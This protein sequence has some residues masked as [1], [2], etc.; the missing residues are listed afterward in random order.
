MRNDVSPYPEV[1]FKREVQVLLWPVSEIFEEVVKGTATGGT[2]IS[3]YC[4]AVSQSDREATIRLS[5]SLP[6]D[7]ATQPRP[8]LIVSINVDGQRFANMAIDGITDYREERGARSMTLTCRSRDSFGL[9]RDNRFVTQVY[10]YGTELSA[11]A[12]DIARAMGLGAFERALPVTGH[13]TPHTNCQ[14]SD[15][16]PWEM[17]TTLYIAAGSSPVFDARG[18]LKTYSRDITRPVDLTIAME[19]VIAITGSKARPPIT[20]VKVKWLSRHLSKVSQQD[21][22]ITRDTVT[23]GFFKLE[24]RREEWFSEDRTQRA[25]KTYMKV[26]QSVNSGLLPVGDEEYMQL[27]TRHGELVVTTSAWVPALATASIIAMFAAT[28]I[29]DTVAIFE[30]IPVGRIIHGA[31]EVAILLTMMSLGTG[32]YEFWGQPFDYVHAINTT[33]AFAK[34]AP[35]WADI[36]RLIECDFITNEN[37]AKTVAVMELLFESAQSVSWG[38][39]IV[40][41]PRLEIGDIISL[42]DASRLFITGYNRDLSRGEEAVLNIQ[43][44]RC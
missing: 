8:G 24:Q 14:M 43:G 33:E 42:P 32:Q 2:D 16:S 10:S 15:M 36:E 7:C 23:A 5:G 38:C 11:I 22:I 20:N 44:F 13:V 3:P 35:R 40:D 21:Q 41:D 18:I 9:W 19:R 26:I 37:H 25:E 30:T 34:S 29:P 39:S 17:L 27:S 4:S 12:R 28:A 31:A 6:F 1:N